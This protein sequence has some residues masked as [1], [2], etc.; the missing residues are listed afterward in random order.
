MRR[1]AERWAPSVFV[2]LTATPGGTAPSTRVG[3]AVVGGHDVVSRGELGAEGNVPPDGE[4][5]EQ[6]RPST[7][8]EDDEAAH[9]RRD[10]SRPAALHAALLRARR[11][12]PGPGWLPPCSGSGSRSASRVLERRFSAS[13][14]RADR[15]D[16]RREQ[17]QPGER[18][19]QIQEVGEVSMLARRLEQRAADGSRPSS[20][21]PAGE[22]PTAA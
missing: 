15:G 9:Q 7:S 10:R 14:G 18:R 22:P 6:R 4:R 19:E 16:E 8:D 13:S 3:R 11:R 5:P 20:T 17:R 12:R 1:R 2:A 21:I